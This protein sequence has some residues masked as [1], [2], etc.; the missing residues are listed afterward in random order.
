MTQSS[1]NPIITNSI[2]RCQ[3]RNR[4]ARQCKL[5]ALAGSP[6]C[7]SH[8]QAQRKENAASELACAI[9]GGR[10]LFAS[11]SDINQ[12]LSQVLVAA[13]HKRLSSR[14][15]TAL[16]YICSL[17]LR[18]T[19]MLVQEK[20]REEKLSSGESASDEPANRVW[21]LFDSS[22]WMP[23][24]ARRALGRLGAPQSSNE[25][26]RESQVPAAPVGAQG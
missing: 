3:H 16:V 15:A 17:L 4:A 22:S 25:Q 13:V 5:P 2:S 7:Y 24:V 19:T 6:L 12:V 10:S 20:L 1:P 23:A 21:E 18:S 11:A 9:L 14:E 26:E 8:N